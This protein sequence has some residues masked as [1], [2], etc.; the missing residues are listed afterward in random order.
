MKC[1]GAVS[2]RGK[3]VDGIGSGQIARPF[4]PGPFFPPCGCRYGARAV[5][6][7]H[8]SV[9]SRCGPTSRRTN[10]S[11]P[12]CC[13]SFRK[14]RLR[15]PQRR[16]ACLLQG[17][18][19]TPHE[20]RRAF[21]CCS[22]KTHSGANCSATSRCNSTNHPRALHRNRSGERSPSIVSAR[23][24][25]CRRISFVAI[26]SIGRVIAADAQCR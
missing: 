11:A 25:T 24:R 8:C 22:S 4:A 9:G 16:P 26:W 15:R 17:Y 5:W 6:L 23:P 14:R 20:P 2:R 18:K 19:W 13:A 7:L 10:W 12:G 21:A 3:G 1:F